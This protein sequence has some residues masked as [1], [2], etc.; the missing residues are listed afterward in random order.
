[1]PLSPKNSLT[2]PISQ[3]MPCLIEKLQKYNQIIL[4]APT[5][6]GKSTY[7]PLM[8]IKEKV[9][10]G[11]VILLEPRR[12]AARNV[13]LYLAQQLGERVGRTVGYRMRGDTKVSIHTKIEVVTEAILTRMIQNDPELNGVDLVI[14]DEFH[15]RSIHADTA[16]ALCLEIQSALRDDLTLLIMSATLEQSSFSQHLPDAV[17]IESKGKSYPVTVH[18]QPLN[19]QQPWLEEIAKAVLSATRSELGVTLV[20]LPSVVSIKQ[21]AERLHEKH[22]NAMICQLYGRLSIA[23]QQQ[24]ISGKFGEHG[25]IVLTTN[26]A[27]TSLTIDGVSL[28]IDSGLE[29]RADYN[30]KTGITKLEQKWISQ[31]SAIQRSGRAGRLA[32]GR[33]LRLYSESQFQQ[34]AKQA[35]P[36]ILR[37]DLSS[38]AMEMFVW[39]CQQANDLI[40]LDPPSNRQWQ[41]A[42]NLLTQLQLIDNKGRATDLLSKAYQFGLDPRLASML[43]S[44]EALPDSAMKQQML[45]SAVLSCALIEESNQHSAN[46]EH[47]VADYQKRKS[48]NQAS[49]ERQVAYLLQKLDTVWE[50]INEQSVIGLALSYA[51]PDRVAQSRALYSAQSNSGFLLANGHGAKLHTHSPLINNDYLI[52]IELITA[53][54]KASVITLAVPLDIC[55]LRKQRPDMFTTKQQVEW[56]DEKQKIIARKQLCWGELVIE[57]SHLEQIDPQLIEAALLSLVKKQGLQLFEPSTQTLQL[58]ERVKCAKEWLPDLDWPDF[59]SEALLEQVESWLLPYL[60]GVTTAKKLVKLSLSDMLEA[61]LG[62]DLLTV[63]NKQL[64]TAIT[65]PTGG[66]KRLKYQQG[67]APF[68]AI[69]MQEIFGESRSPTVVNGQIN[70]VLE[71]LSPA[72]RPLQITQDLEAFW[73]GGYQEVKKE[74]RGRYPKHVWPDAPQEHQA[75][76]KTKRQLNT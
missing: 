11:K 72:M 33:C 49:I 62:W 37:S 75:T 63:L 30:Q 64:P 50:N 20:F 27:E 9:F 47:W 7:L 36:E 58:I 70:V 24:A 28:V 73:Q 60:H 34:M 25:K 45:S 17:F 52:A 74:M 16:L 48:S 42:V 69:R 15:E 61:Y 31:S 38:L 19:K 40:W 43:I 39:G 12:L 10:S 32:D 26:V 1:M 14:L 6:A 65:V 46:M 5:G 18:Y 67:S 29:K 68:L 71:L 56:S 53:E 22:C 76:T 44:I 23:E 51:Y 2:P 66:Q 3:I 4:K 59:S 41:S 54:Q 57:E 35:T 8:L 13:A 55:L 21:V